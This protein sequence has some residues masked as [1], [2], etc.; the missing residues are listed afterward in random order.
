VAL[1]VAVIVTGYRNV[2]AAYSQDRT[3]GS[4][5]IAYFAAAVI[6][7]LTE[8]GFRMMS[9]VWLGFLLAIIYVPS[10]RRRKKTVPARK[11]IAVEQGELYPSLV[12]SYKA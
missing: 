7:S 10:M 11:S 8:A 9:P 5:K 4:I 2:L 1:L 3:L 12:T 6:Y